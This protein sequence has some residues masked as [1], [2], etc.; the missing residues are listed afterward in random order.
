M[1]TTEVDTSA[2]YFIRSSS[3]TNERRFPVVSGFAFR[4]HGKGPLGEGGGVYHKSSC[5]ECAI[6]RDRKVKYRDWP[7]HI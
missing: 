3:A 2:V 4:G 7:V 1:G 6:Q 5:F